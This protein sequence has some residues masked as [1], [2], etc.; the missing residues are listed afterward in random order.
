V[1]GD[2]DAL[3]TRGVGEVVRRVVYVVAH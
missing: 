3:D 2:R 1:L